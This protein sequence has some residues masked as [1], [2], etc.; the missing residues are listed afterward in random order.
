MSAKILLVDDSKIIRSQVRRSLEQTGENYEIGEA[1]DGLEAL[2][3]LSVCIRKNLPDVIVL[4]RNMPNMSGDECIRI[5]KQDDHWQKIPVL[6][7]TAQAD[8]SQLVL[9][10]AELGADDY[11]SKPFDPDELAAR[12]KVL[13]RIKLAE[14]ESRQLNMDLE[15][16]LIEQQRAYEELKQTKLRL[17]ET[18]A[19]AKLT[20]IFEKFVPKEFIR[21]IAPDGLENLKF[22][23]AESDLISILF[24]DIRSFTDLSEK[25]TP[26]E[27]VDFF[28]GYLQQMNNPIS[29]NQ[30]FV[31]KFIG[32]AIMVL[33]SLPG[34]PNNIEAINAVKAA[35]GMQQ[36][37]DIFNN[38]HKDSWDEPLRVGIGVHSGPVIIG[39]VG[40]EER[41]DSTVMGDTV[42]LASRLEGLTKFYGSKI[43]I[44]QPTFEFIE[45]E[46]SFEIREIDLVMVKGKKKPVTIY[47]VCNCDP[48]PIR[49]QK[50]ES[51]NNFSEGLK[52]YRASKWKQAITKFKACVKEC[53]SDRTAE[54]YIDRCKIYQKNPPPKNWAGEQIFDH[55]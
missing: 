24:C 2:T 20:G 9:G 32:D 6:F 12:L 36:Q 44:S 46:D 5:L 11:L 31:D 21:R 34:E 54:I 17:A 39:T 50:M 37:V 30:G 55:K 10:L 1:S 23:Q 42:N 8:I 33:F 26:Q 27:L 28:N 3:S 49:E 22:G 18:E 40:S 52:N 53:P 29:V 47:E 41:M 7:L 13:I 38:E 4:D 19:A 51:K 14:D 25:L 43:I 16:S 45:Q 15:Q 48:D 35:I